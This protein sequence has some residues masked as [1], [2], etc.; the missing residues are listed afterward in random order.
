[1]EGAARLI[2]QRPVQIDQQIAAGYQVDVREG[3]IA[4]NAVLSKDDK[5]AHLA[6]DEIVIAFSREELAQSFFGDVGLDGYRIT[7]FARG[8]QGS[9]IEVRREQ[10]E[11]GAVILASCFFKHKDSD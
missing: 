9:G 1:M 7:S 4:Q 2:L 11:S 8:R 10:L 5:V 3:G 6:F